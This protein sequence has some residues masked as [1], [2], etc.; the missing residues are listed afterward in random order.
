MASIS[1]TDEVANYIA[2]RVREDLPWC[3]T[4]VGIIAPPLAAYIAVRG[5]DDGQD[6]LYRKDI[7]KFCTP[8]GLEKFMSAAGRDDDEI[9]SNVIDDLGD[10]CKVVTVKAKK[11][12][13]LANPSFLKQIRYE[14]Y[15]KL[16]SR[17]G[18]SDVAV[19]QR[20]PLPILAELLVKAT[21]PA[22]DPAEFT[23]FV[24]TNIAALHEESTRRELDEDAGASEPASQADAGAASAGGK[25]KR[26]E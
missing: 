7:A 8:E 25:R 11:K 13:D 10:A 17:Y 2:S 4:P 5:G 16:A 23:G 24:A 21:L 22:G 18:Y 20:I 19:R 26:A 1:T 3:P 12:A 9:V 15:R 14:A 6:A